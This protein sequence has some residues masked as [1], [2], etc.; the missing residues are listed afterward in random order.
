MPTE[1][2]AAEE[3]RS[4][5]ES[6]EERA[7]DRSEEPNEQRAGGLQVEDRATAAPS[8]TAAFRREG[9]PGEAATIDWGEYRAASFGG[10]AEDLSPIR[11]PGIDLGHDR[12]WIY[13]A[14]PQVAVGADVT[15]VQ[16]LRQVSRTLATPAN[17]V[18]AID[19]TTAK[20]ETDTALELVTVALQQ[21]ASVSSGIPNVVLA[22]DGVQSLIETDLRLALDE[23]LDSLVLAE[24]AAIGNVAPGTNPLLVN[25]RRARTAVEAEGYAPDTVALSPEDAEAL[26]TLVAESGTE[27]YVFPAGGSAPGSIFGLRVRVSKAVS[28]P[29]VLDSSSV[30]RL[31]ASPVSVAVFEEND[32]STNTSLVRIESHAA[33]A[34][35]RL[36]AAVRIGTAT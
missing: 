35:E 36:D 3:R 4:E 16:V 22:Q 8:L 6:G 34:V 5:N 20:P 32:G 24:L 2:G 9:F 19:A 27:H 11:R 31:Y 33:A 17:V 30:G 15:S 18:R 14:L 1:D 26:D 25:I 7:E 29:I 10:N 28:D 12:R 23:A 21:V 13:P